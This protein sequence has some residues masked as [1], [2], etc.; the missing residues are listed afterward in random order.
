[1]RPMFLHGDH[2]SLR[3]ICII[4]NTLLRESHSVKR[5]YYVEC[6]YVCVFMPQHCLSDACLWNAM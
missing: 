5:G 4:K 2:F 6:L 1:M 3:K